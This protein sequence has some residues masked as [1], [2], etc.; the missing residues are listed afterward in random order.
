MNRHFKLSCC[1]VPSGI[2]SVV[3]ELAFGHMKANSDPT[4]P[5]SVDQF[6]WPTISKLW[7]LQQKSSRELTSKRALIVHEEE[8]DT[9]DA[10]LVEL[11][12]KMVENAPL[13]SA[14][15]AFDLSGLLT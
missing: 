7:S 8:V 6:G 12:R 3:Y 15:K 1:N 13:T 9:D 14:A 11:R 4:V 10:K 5:K 2:K